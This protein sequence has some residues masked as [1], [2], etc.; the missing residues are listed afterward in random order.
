MEE[1]K[2]T[3]RSIPFSLLLR[4]IFCL[5]LLLPLSVEAQTAREHTSSLAIDWR[6]GDFTLSFTYPVEERMDLSPRLRRDFSE[7]SRSE[8]GFTFVREFFTRRYSSHRSVEDYMKDYPE[9]AVELS[10]R[11]QKTYTA[12]SGN[13]N[14][15][16]SEFRISYHAS[17]YPD[18]I[19]TFIRHDIASSPSPLLRYVPSGPFSGIVIYV[20]EGLPLYGASRS[21]EITPALFPKIYNENMELLIS[22]EMISPKAMKRWGMVGYYSKEEIGSIVERVG[23]VPIYTKAT[24]LFGKTATDIVIPRRGSELILSTEETIDLI[25]QGKIAIVHNAHLD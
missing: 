13:F 9:T 6:N 14:Q 2:T 20:E 7:R 11:V 8:L 22:R 10:S 19:E 12:S 4:L 5:T 23:E 1:M 16:F 3:N 15:E 24:A 21:A 25:R 18:I 17:L